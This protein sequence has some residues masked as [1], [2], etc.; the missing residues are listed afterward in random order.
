MVINIGL[1]TDPMFGAF[2]S[3][4]RNSWSNPFINTFL[5]FNGQ[6]LEGLPAIPVFEALVGT[7]V[8]AGV[9]YYLARPAWARGSGRA[10]RRH[11]R[12]GHRLIQ[13]GED[14]TE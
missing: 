9:I 14:V 7:I 5:K 6:V 4:L 1:W 12:G 3:D 2:G 11:R 10:G 8:I 13:F